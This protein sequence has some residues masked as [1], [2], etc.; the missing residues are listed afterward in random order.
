MFLNIEI[1]KIL[2]FFSSDNLNF[3][4]Y[5]VLEKKVKNILDEL[6]KKKENRT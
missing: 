6:D 4:V 2:M 3:E 1:I 5:H